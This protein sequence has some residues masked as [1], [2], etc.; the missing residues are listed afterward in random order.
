MISPAQSPRISHEISGE[1]KPNWTEPSVTRSLQRWA[2]VDR[3]TSSTHNPSLCARNY[4]RE[5]RRVVF[6]SWQRGES[7][8]F[9]LSTCWRVCLSELDPPR[10]TDM[11]ESWEN[12]SHECNCD[13]THICVSET[14]GTRP[15]HVKQDEIIAWRLI[16]MYAFFSC[17]ANA[18][19]EWTK[20]KLIIFFKE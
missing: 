17:K 6:E 19:L 20:H 5:P 2:V 15:N 4:R 12:E 1:S 10:A 13:D 14:L 3:S 9:S 16:T 7:R 8:D 18:T 11:T